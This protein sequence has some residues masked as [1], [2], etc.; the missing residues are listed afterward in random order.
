MELMVLAVP[1]CPNAPVLEQRLA[2]VLADGPAATV[3]RRVI[4]EAH[5]S[6]C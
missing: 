2:E 5:V 6:M 4:A 3:T 1:G